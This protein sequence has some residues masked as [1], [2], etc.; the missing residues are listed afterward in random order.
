MSFDHFNMPVLGEH[1]HGPLDQVEEERD[2]AIHESSS[3]SGMVKRIRSNHER[4][5]NSLTMERER[6]QKLAQISTAEC[7][8]L[9]EELLQMHSLVKESES[10]LREAQKLE[11]DTRDTM[12]QKFEVHKAE[13]SEQIKFLKKRLEE[14]LE[15]KRETVVSKFQDK[16]METNASFQ[17]SKREAEEAK[18]KYERMERQ[19]RAESI[20][21]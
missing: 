5:V 1:L 12:A 20:Q 17:A 11:T 15:S 7:K 2:A 18:M 13:S 19:A 10:V 16:D 8:K 4:L 3:T 21:I 14:E 9:Q 6:E